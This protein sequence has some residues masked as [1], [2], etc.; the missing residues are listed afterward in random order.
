[1]TVNTTP[2]SEERAARERVRSSRRA[3]AAKAK[4]DARRLA[5]MIG[6]EPASPDSRRRPGA[7][8]AKT[9]RA[10]RSD[11][12]PHPAPGPPAR[13][14]HRAR[15][16][17]PAHMSDPAP[18]RDTPPESWWQAFERA[19]RARAAQLRS[20]WQMNPAERVAAMR[21]GE[22]TSQQLAAWTARHP[23]QVPIVQDEFEWILAKL[24]EVCE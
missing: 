6:Q 11:S 17:P 12:A 24:P 2:Q 7:K 16:Q 22:L 23:D 10:P 20:L 9:E 14:T 5:A 21:P 15:D 8:Q 19:E 13:G 18:N 4:T 1:M 3:P